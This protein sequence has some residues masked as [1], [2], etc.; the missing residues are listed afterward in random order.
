MESRNKTDLRRIP[1]TG[2][3]PKQYFWLGN[4]GIAQ[5]LV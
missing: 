4:K 5:E 2:E 3:K 1:L